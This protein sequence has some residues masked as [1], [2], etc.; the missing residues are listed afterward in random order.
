MISYGGEKGSDF[1]GS[2]VIR[3]GGGGE[4]RL[5]RLCRGGG[6]RGDG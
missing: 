6:V 4:T 5:P 2:M 3:R 1:L